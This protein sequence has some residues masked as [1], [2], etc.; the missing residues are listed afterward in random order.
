MKAKR[1]SIASRLREAFRLEPLEP[2]VL[3]SADPVLGAAAIVVPQR[4]DQQQVQAEV[5]DSAQRGVVSQ[6]A[7]EASSQVVNQILR[8][9][10]ASRG[11]T[12]FAVDAA[13]YDIAKVQDSLGFLQGA[14]TV[15]PGQKLG[16]SGTIP[17]TVFNDGV[18]SPGYSPGVDNISGDYN[19]TGTLLI[20]LGGDTAG[21]GTGH[22]DQLNVS[23]KATLGGTLQLALYGGFKPTDG[24]TFDVLTFGSVAGKF[25][26]GTGFVQEDAGVWFSIDQLATG[27]RLTAHQIDPT[28]Q[29]LLDLFP[30]SPTEKIG[31]WINHGY[32]QDFDPV[33]FTGTVSVGTNLFLDGT[34]TFG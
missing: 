6:Q 30:S 21:T 12:E 28:L 32:F 19:Q 18:V 24:Q 11:M 26:V 10:G 22:Y 20:E 4:D 7:T 13:T 8:Q 23:G 25:D 27:L 34:F 2:R 17:L 33:T 9:A 3:L 14:L 5:Y 16:G 15:E 29:Y 1:S 31:E